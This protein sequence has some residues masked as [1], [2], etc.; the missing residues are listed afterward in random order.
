MKSVSISIVLYKPD[1]DSFILVIESLVLAVVQL[2]LAQQC[3]EVALIV[4]D[5]SAEKSEECFEALIGEKW[6]GTLHFIQPTENLGFAKGH[7][8]AIGLSQCDYHLILNPD[9]I[10]DLNTL[11]N[12]W[13]YLEN[14]SQ[15]VL[16]SPQ[17]Y[18]E[19]GERQYLCKAYPTILDL[20]LRGFTPRWCQQKFAHRLARYELKGQTE[21]NELSSVLIA[22]GCFMFLRRESF[23]KIGGFS[24]DF[25]LYFEDFDLSIR[26]Q[27]LGDLAYVPDVKIVH[28]G[29]QAAKKGA[30]HI[31]LFV[32]SMCLFFKKHGWRW[33]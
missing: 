21:E 24:E 6:K 11:V 28:F 17:A 29:G 3:D 22:S 15:A 25:F 23:V 2:K 1:K 26:L 10:L 9:V 20:F 13:S 7:N 14:H 32:Q 4:L 19:S 18:T 30:W 16:V 27:K 31:I 8:Q 12:A 33:Y 5:N